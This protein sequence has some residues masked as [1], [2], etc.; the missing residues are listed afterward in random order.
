[1]KQNH[2]QPPSTTAHLL[3]LELFLLLPPLPSLLLPFLGRL[4]SILGNHIREV[5]LG[6]RNM[7]TTGR[8]TAFIVPLPQ[9]V[10]GHAFQLG[11]V[12]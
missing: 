6:A 5:F 12:D 1:M 2:R 8:T 7:N 3:K 10:F 9:L 11:G 4:R